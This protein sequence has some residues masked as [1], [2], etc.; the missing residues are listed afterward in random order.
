MTDTPELVPAPV[1]ETP[2][3]SLA[4]PVEPPKRLPLDRHPVAVLLGTMTSIHSRRTYASSLDQIAAMVS[5]LTGTPFTK[6]TLPWWLLRY[7]HVARIKVEIAQD[8]S[9]ASAN[10][11]LSS[12]VMSLRW[13]MGQRPM[14]FLI[15]AAGSSP[16]YLIQ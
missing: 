2:D 13:M 3:L 10:V 12:A 4:L 9:P 7:P 1:P 14:Y 11:R 5:R 8:L 6:E 16:P 15:R